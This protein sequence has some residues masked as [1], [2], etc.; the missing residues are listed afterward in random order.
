MANEIRSFAVPYPPTTGDSSLDGWMRG[1][2]EAINNLPISIF[3]TAD[4]PNNSLV[5][6]PEG[7]IGIEVGSASTLTK[8]WFK[9]SGST[10]T[11]WTPLNKDMTDYKLKVS[12]GVISGVSTVNKFGRNPLINTASDPEDVWD[13]GGIH[14]GPVAASTL[15]VVSSNGSDDGQESTATYT[16]ARTVRIYGLTDWDTAEVSE[17]VT[18]KGL[19]AVQTGN[20]YVFVHRA[21]VL[22]AGSNTTNQGN[23]DIAYKAPA[24]DST[25]ARITT[26]EGQTLM[27]IYGVPSTD[28]LYI[29]DWHLAAN[30]SGAA[31]SC[32]IQ[33][34]VI[35]NADTAT[36]V[37][38]VKSHLGLQTDGTSV[39]DHFFDP[40][41]KISGPAIV[42]VQVKE[43]SQNG[44]DVSAGFDAFL[45][46]NTTAL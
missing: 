28:K 6:S 11:G 45:V 35:D 1:V 13:L 34:R 20:S 33:L 7:F 9:E 12:A 3:S 38:K 36:K 44:F 22:T 30:K 4:G 40:Y 24:S 26:G 27:T 2:S 43:V 18:L 16:G 31:G 15:T 23:I 19:T 39:A 46:K 10:S 8:F 21:E 29:D 17:D 42:K 14:P 37:E 41:F 25:L 32:S 5:T